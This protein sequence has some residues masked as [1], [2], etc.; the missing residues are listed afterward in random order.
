MDDLVN[1]YQNQID[2][3]SNLYDAIDQSTNEIIKG[4]QEEI[5]YSRQIRDNTK[6]EEDIADKEARLAYLRRDTSGANAMEIKKL[7]EDIANSREQYSDTMVDQ[8]ITDMQNEAQLAAEQRQ[9]QIEIM[10][11]QLDVAQK[12][13]ELWGK[14]WDLINTATAADGTFSQNSELV[15]LM[16]ETEAFQSLSVV[17]QQKWWEDAA[18]AFLRAQTGLSEA[19][20]KYGVD[21]NGDGSVSTTSSSASSSAGSSSSSTS[22]SGSDISTEG[23]GHFAK[24]GTYE[25]PMAQMPSNEVKELQQ[26]LNDAG[27]TDNE[28]NALKT[29]GIYGSRTR[30]SV[31]KLQEK[32][33]NVK[34][35]GY[36][37]PET[38]SATLK[39][40]FKA[41]ATGGLAD[42]TGP[43]WLDGTKSSP[44]LVLN[45][46]DTE[47]FIALKNI[48]ANL[49]GGQG[50]DLI[51]N[52]G[53]DNYFD[54]HIDAEIGS[55]YDVDRLAE[56]IEKKIYEKSSYRNVNTINYLR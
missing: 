40:Q 54:I 11:N 56:K 53:G 8:Q 30:Q 6:K 7:E 18:E 24:V 32:L 33:G 47:N 19:E 16:M 35:D 44:E 43:A 39:S 52:K 37:G 46:K 49:L 51:G 2:E 20:G 15:N 41:F 28:G 48:L 55:D 31:W 27:F 45:A 17:G 29:D 3:L 22:G 12:N 36:Y 14:V 10:Q 38:R 25:H 42:F 9:H 13:G 1:H 50:G 5:N 26:A 4:I 23:A 21:A 34:V